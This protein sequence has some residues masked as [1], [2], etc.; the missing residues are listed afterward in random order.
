MK[1]KTELNLTPENDR[2][3]QELV[4]SIEASNGILSL[5]I[6][7]CDDLPLRE[8]II[9]E[10]ERELQPQFRPYR[11]KLARDE[12]SLRM[13][14]ASQV[15]TDI[16]LQQRTPAILTVTGA[17]N[18]LFFSP[19]LERS[20]QDKFFGYLQWTREGL[21]E[22][23][24]PIVL[25]IT[26]QILVNMMTKAPDFWSWR[27]GVFRFV[28]Q[29]PIVPS[30]LRDIQFPSLLREDN[31]QYFLPLEDMKEL[32]ATTEKLRGVNHPRLATLYN[33]LGQIYQKRLEQGEADN[34]PQ[35][36]ELAI[37]CFQKAIK[38][39]VEWSLQLNLLDT[40]NN[41]G[42][43]YYWQSQ[44]QQAIDC[45]QQEL[46][47]AIEIG[48]RSGEAYS[49]ANLGNV[50]SSLGQYRK[51]IDCYQL[52]LVIERE[53]GNRGGEAYSLGN[54][55]N[56]YSSLEQYR[57]AI[58]YYQLSLVIEREIGNRGGEAYYLSNL[59][60]TYSS[61]GQYRKAIDY[62]QL[63]LVI[64]REIGNRGGEAYYLSNLGDTYSSLG[65]YQKA[66]DYYQQSLKI[67]REIGDIEEEANTLFNL[68][69]TLKQLNRS[70]KAMD[71]YRQ[72]RELY[73]TM[74]LEA[75]VRDCDNAIREIE[76][77]LE[78]PSVR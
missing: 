5:L 59:G 66:I 72:A 35:E 6:A 73:Q 55:G 56:V 68:G 7:V 60:D 71:A 65:Q 21:R 4:V 39:Q 50:Y 18:L 40:L 75:D 11:L 57:K 52:S 23:R 61:L 9:N 51:A 62:Y 42:N 28:R 43:L 45:F 77:N 2:N 27:K 63:S 46:E 76:T 37:S 17:E 12:P 25:W 8:R 29:T 38:L 47:I 3:Y 69:D 24:Y 58:D 53:I 36:R 67:T 70:Q 19:K 44:Y 33:R 64:E 41:L 54:L 14:I 15:Q 31:Q 48:D 78:S 26:Y 10:Y 30:N 22:F 20:Q 13:A 16:Y 49:L 32:I 34:Y 1:Q 74:E